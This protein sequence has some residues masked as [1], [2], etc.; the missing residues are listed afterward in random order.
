MIVYNKVNKCVVC[1]NRYVGSVWEG[2]GAGLWWRGR[3][4][5]GKRGREG[6]REGGRMGRESKRLWA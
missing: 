4:R 1:T 6:G 3:E 5:E 2:V